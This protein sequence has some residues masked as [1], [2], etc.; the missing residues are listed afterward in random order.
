MFI[1]KIDAF[2]RT[3]EDFRN[4]RLIMKNFNSTEMISFRS[5]VVYL[6]K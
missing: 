3:Y 2:N 5:A 6:L 4:I 1:T